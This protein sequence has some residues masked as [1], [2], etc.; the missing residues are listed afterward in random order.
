MGTELWES[1]VAATKR[2]TISASEY[3]RRHDISVADLYYWHGGLQNKDIAMQVGVRARASFALA[4]TLCTITPSGH[5]AR[6]AAWRATG[7]GGCGSLGGIDYREQG[8]SNL[9]LNRA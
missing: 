8:V 2:E 5:R 9:A 3:A 7:E 4:R 1:H 6:P